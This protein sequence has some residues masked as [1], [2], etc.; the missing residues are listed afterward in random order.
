M[1]NLSLIL[2]TSL[3]LACG[4][5]ESPEDETAFVVSGY[6][7][8]LFTLFTCVKEIG[9][10]EALGTS[11]GLEAEV[12]LVYSV[13]FGTR[14]GLSER[15]VSAQIDKEE[16]I[17]SAG[18]DRREET[19][20]LDNAQTSSLQIDA[21]LNSDNGDGQFTFSVNSDVAGFTYTDSDLAEDVTY[22]FEVSQNLRECSGTVKNDPQG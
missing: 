19:Y 9:P 12:K 14:V 22:N 18:F 7:M 11:L 6:D 16:G 10:D 8:D 1:K 4:N 13:L 20:L 5:V 3:G 2:L 17:T 21:D 15:I